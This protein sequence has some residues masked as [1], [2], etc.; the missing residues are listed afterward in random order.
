M[1]LSLPYGSDFFVSLFFPHSALPLVLTF[2]KTYPE[3]FLHYLHRW[4]FDAKMITEIDDFF[5][6][7][8]ENFLWGNCGGRGSDRTRYFLGSYED[9]DT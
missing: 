9:K 1:F 6:P 4:I 3:W 5:P 7:W 2:Q 8:I